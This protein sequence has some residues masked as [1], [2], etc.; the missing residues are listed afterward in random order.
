MTLHIAFKTGSIFKSDADVLVNPVNTVG[1]MGAGLALQFKSKYPNNYK[2]Y[3]KY[4]NDVK[5]FKDYDLCY[6]EEKDKIIYN[7]PSKENFN[8]FSSLGKVRRSLL[9]LVDYL[10]STEVESI[11]IPPIGAGLGGLDVMNVLH[12]VLYYLRR[13]ERPIK[14]ELYGFKIK[15]TVQAHIVQRY[16]FEYRE[17]DKYCG[18]GSRET[19]ETGEMKITYL[20]SVLNCNGYTLSTGD[21]SKGADLMFWVCNKTQKFRFGPFGRKPK[22]DTIV[23]PESS[24]IH[25]VAAIIAGA[26]HPAWRFLP[27][28]MKEL[29]TRNVF[30][31]L[32]K[33]VS[34]PCEFVLCWT[35]DGAERT[36]QTSKQT[37]GTGTAI[38]VAHRF[39]VPV[40][41]LKNEDALV[42]L[43]EFLG[44]NFIDEYAKKSR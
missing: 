35:P 33:D 7:L 30:Q 11:A 44:I 31:V 25:S 21:A 5:S 10:N 18:V 3:R 23:V 43:G 38:K 39:G 40:F 20:A 8:Q 6:F 16:D 17:Q 41:N 9:K 29:H 1:V 28:W 13:V 36:D 24:P 42:K 12:L 15:P 34:E 37:G 2:H 14:I 4:C 32:G 27:P 22:P 19:D 26:V